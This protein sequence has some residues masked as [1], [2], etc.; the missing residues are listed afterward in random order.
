MLAIDDDIANLPGR[1]VHHA[2][3]Q[4]QVHI[5]LADHG[6]VVLPHGLRL[7]GEGQAVV[8]QDDLIGV[9]GGKARTLHRHALLIIGAMYPCDGIGAAAA[10]HPDAAGDGVAVLIH[11]TEVCRNNPI[12]D[13]ICSQGAVRALHLDGEAGVNILLGGCRLVLA[14]CGLIEQI[15]CR[16]SRIIRVIRIARAAGPAS[17]GA[18]IARLAGFPGRRVPCLPGILLLPD[19]HQMGVNAHEQFRRLRPGKLAVRSEAVVAVPLE[20]TAAPQVSRGLPGV[21]GNGAVVSRQAVSHRLR[22]PR[23]NVLKIPPEKRGH[24]GTGDGLVRGESPLSHAVG[25]PGGHR[26]GH[27]GRV[28]AA[29]LHVGERGRT[30]IVRRVH[31]GQPAQNGHH[32]GPSHRPVRRKLGVRGAPEDIVTADILHSVIEPRSLRHV[33]ERP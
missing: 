10:A 22:K 31:L 17:A 29:R 27:I 32:H 30:G 5:L 20:N 12:R 4:L 19:V 13:L 15:F 1:D 16:S 24:L 33:H 21:G 28:P 26:P 2:V 8:V 25:D 9:A 18:G 7:A 3:G 11:G 23:A 14:G 6:E